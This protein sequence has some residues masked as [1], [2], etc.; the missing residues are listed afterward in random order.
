V[1]NNAGI[2]ACAPFLSTNPKSI[3]QVFKVNVLA[4]FWILRE[5]LPKMI[6]TRKG[7][8][9][10]L[11]SVA[12]FQ[13]TKH[14]VPYVGTKHAV[15]GYVEALKDE[16]RHHPEKPDIQFTTVYPYSVNTGLLNNVAECKP[17]FSGLLPVIEPS[18]V[19]ERLVD[20]MR[21]NVEY[22][23]CPPIVE[24]LATY[25]KSIHVKV[26]RAVADFVQAGVDPKFNK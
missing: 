24:F 18:Y 7:H 21:R 10:T 2:M 8:I 20:G 17:R 5:F 1:I 4:H 26:Q 23:Y 22:V 15:H 6:E 25:A 16:M 13:A 3:E 14:I 19:A 11:C 9:V 12:G